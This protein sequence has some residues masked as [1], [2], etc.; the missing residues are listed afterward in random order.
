MFFLFIVI[1]ESC[2]KGIAFSHY[3]S[4]ALQRL[5]KASYTGDVRDIC[6]FLSFCPEESGVYDIVYNGNVDSKH[7]G[8]YSVYIFN[9]T[10]QKSRE[11]RN[12][13]LRDGTCYEV[14]MYHA[15]YNGQAWGR[16]EYTHNGVTR[17]FSSADSFTCPIGWCKNGGVFPACIQPPTIEFTEQESRISKLFVLLFGLLLQ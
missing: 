16:L 12:L 7:E 5:D 9:G 8:E 15:T 14:R 1:P 13:E 4:S 10:R 6:F 11:F 17:V 3:Y 2:E